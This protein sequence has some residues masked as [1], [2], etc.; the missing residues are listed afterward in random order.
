MGSHP[1][2]LVF[3]IL[4]TKR[5]IQENEELTISYWA[6]DVLTNVNDFPFTLCMC[7]NVQLD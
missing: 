4:V 2:A 6:C 1:H 7:S 3:L 5:E